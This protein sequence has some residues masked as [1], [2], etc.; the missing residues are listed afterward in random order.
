M[1]RGFKPS[2]VLLP[3]NPQGWRRLSSR[4]F[5]ILSTLNSIELN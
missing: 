1:E 4:L 3:S 2:L 5:Q